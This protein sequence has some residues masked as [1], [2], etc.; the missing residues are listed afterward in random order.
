MVSAG[1]PDS[2]PC[3]RI[4][5]AALEHNYREVVRL[6]GPKTAVLAMVKADAYGHGAPAVA[7]RLARA[8]CRRFGVATLDEAEE[9]GALAAD[10]SVV[11][12]GG[13]VPAEADRAI[14]LGAEIVVGDL[15]TARALDGAARSAGRRARIHLKIDTGMRR[16][17][18]EPADAGAFARELRRMPGIEVA[19]LC[20]HFAMAESVTTEVT[21]GQLERLLEASR[22]VDPVLGR[23][24]LHLANS[25]AILTRPETHL[26]MVR[27]GLMLYGLPPDPSLDGRADLRPVMT[28][29]ATVVRVTEVGP[30]EGIGYGHTCR[31]ER[32]TVLA[33]LRCGYADGYPRS[34]SNN[35][36]ALV[37]GRRCPVVGRVCMDHT[38]IDV[39]G[40]RVRIGDRVELWGSG[41]D[42]GEVAARAGTIAYELV[43]R[44]GGR[45][46]RTYEE[47]S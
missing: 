40:A 36:E 43:A 2:A 10:H 38:M 6:V 41:I 13:I 25:A 8:G 42:A 32:N 22:G 34:L 19:A 47:E 30:G 26:D 1:V 16:L 15:D 46:R 29:V 44:V 14:A 21:R 5:L 4:D 3:A 39:T 37:G 18:I 24:P 9:L 33:T 28:L 27:P 7:E 17:G 35:G 31:T 45:V 20:S 11:V 12:F 23:V